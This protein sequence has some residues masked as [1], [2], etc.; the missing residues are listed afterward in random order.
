MSDT[1]L[2]IDQGKFNSVLGWYKTTASTAGLLF[3]RGCQEETFGRP[4]GTVRRPATIEC[5]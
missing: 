4:S 5:E 3:G 2:S 1:I